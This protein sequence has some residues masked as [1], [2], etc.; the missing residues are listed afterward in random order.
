MIPSVRVQ[1][2]GL[3]SPRFLIQNGMRQGCFLLPLLFALILEPFLR[4]VR[5]SPDIKG[6]T[7]ATTEHK[8]SAYTDDVLFHLTGPIVSL[9]NLMRELQLFGRISDFKI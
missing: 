1:V 5:A 2:N 9:P 7:I 8:L 4:T 6:I 3:V